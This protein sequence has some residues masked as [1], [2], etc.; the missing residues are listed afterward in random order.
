L[1]EQQTGDKAWC[2]T[3]IFL[4]NEALTNGAEKVDC[5]FFS[6]AIYSAFQQSWKMWEAEA[7]GAG[8][9]EDG[10]SLLTAR[11]GRSFQG[12]QM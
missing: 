7:P 11:K 4:L 6:F 5:L 2:G 10:K 12:K 3:F 1:Q 9:T 8:S